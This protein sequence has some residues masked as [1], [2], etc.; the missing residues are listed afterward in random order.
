MCRPLGLHKS[1][2]VLTLVL[3]FSTRLKAAVSLSGIL[4]A[5]INFIHMGRYKIIEDTSSSHDLMRLEVAISETILF[6]VLGMPVI[7]LPGPKHH[8]AV[9]YGANKWVPAKLA[10][11]TDG[12]FYVVLSGFSSN[13]VPEYEVYSNG[14]GAYPQ[15]I[16]QWRIPDA[17]DKRRHEFSPREAEA[18]NAMHV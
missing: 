17:T 5:D 2:R 18:N 15:F 3:I 13:A 11:Y 8:R 16:K 4:G 12:K 1:K 10:R 7:F 14:K 6:D 9:L